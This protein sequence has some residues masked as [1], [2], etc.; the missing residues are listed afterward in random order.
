[1]S[2]LLEIEVKANRI[3]YLQNVDEVAL[4]FKLRSRPPEGKILT[5]EEI[6]EI[7]YDFGILRRLK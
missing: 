6:E 1:M 3:E 5:R 2:E 4:I 7:G